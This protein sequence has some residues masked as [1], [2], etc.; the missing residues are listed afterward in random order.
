MPT[1]LVSSVAIT[2]GAAP[3]L[4]EE[5]DLVAP[6]LIKKDPRYVEAL[7]KRGITDL[8]KVQIDPWGVGNMAVPGVLDYDVDGRRLAGSV[9]YYRDFPD[10]N[11]YAHPIEGVIAVV[12]LVTL[13]V[14]EVHDFGVRPMN[15][16]RPTTPPTPTSPC[17]PTSRRWRSLS[18]RASGFVIDGHELTWQKW[19]FRIN[20]HPLEGL[21]LHAVE[22][23]DGGEY[24]SVL[25][26]AS[27]GEMVVPYGDP[28]KEHFWRSAFDAGEF[29]LGKLANSLRLGCD[30]LGEIV[31]LDAVIA[32]EDGEPDRRSRTRS[33]STRRTPASSGST[34]TG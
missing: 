25:H 31:Y 22:Y 27:L 15:T 19:R 1:T 7:A 18:P 12:D 21:V 8:D 29:G 34:P 32:G 11:G 17:A 13:E 4:L 16:S 5:F 6:D 30:C 2:D 14:L 28:S 3:V 9:T 26:R 10:D 23:Q 33:A 24:R 20:W